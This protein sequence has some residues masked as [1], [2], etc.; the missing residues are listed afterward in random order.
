MPLFLL[1]VAVPIVEIALFIQIGG[2]I[3]L[4]WTIGIVIVTAV[5]GAVLLRVQGMAALAEVQDA[6][7]RGGNPA[8]AMAH[9]ALILVAAVLLLIPGFFTDGVGFLLLVPP[10]RALVI[11]FLARR[12]TVVQVESRK[13]RFGQ[14]PAGAGTVEGE[15]E[16]IDPDDQTDPRADSGAGS[17]WTRAPGRLPDG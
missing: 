15:Y 3:G 13:D 14:R 1:L 10:V 17:G 6:L 5:L 2:W 11:R 4:W 7:R 9:G 16:I 8:P 12:M